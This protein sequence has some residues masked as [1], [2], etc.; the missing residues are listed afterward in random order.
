MF[1][2]TELDFSYLGYC[3]NKHVKYLTDTVENVNKGTSYLH[4]IVFRNN[5]EILLIVVL[6]LLIFT[7]G[8]AL[9]W[10]SMF[11]QVFL[12]RPVFIW[13]LGDNAIKD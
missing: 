8:F 2:H 13:E 4:Y 5:M 3:T 10:S 6:M 7:F 12:V 11:L 9:A 1:K